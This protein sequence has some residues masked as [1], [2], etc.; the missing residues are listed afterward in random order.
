VMALL[1]AYIIIAKAAPV[2]EEQDLT[3]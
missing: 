3:V 2:Q 1:L